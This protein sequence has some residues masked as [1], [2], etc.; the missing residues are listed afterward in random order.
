MARSSIPNPSD[1][2]PKPEPVN[3]S[4]ERGEEKTPQRDPRQA[5]LFTAFE[6]SGDNLAAPVI[7][8]LLD[9]HPTLTVYAWGGPK[10][11]EAGATL[12]EQTVGDAAMGLGALKK[13]GQV[14]REVR[15]IKRWVKQYRVLAHVPVDSPAANFPICKIIRPTGARIIHLVA[16][17]VWAWAPWRIRK[18]RRLT[19]LVLCVLPFEEQYFNDRKVTA[20]FIGHPRINRGVDK[21][22]IMEAMHGLPSGAPRIALLP[23][24]RPHEVK[25]NLKLLLNAYTELQGRHHGAVGVIAAA[26]EEIG[27]IVRDRIKVFPT[28]LHMTV[29]DIDVP[30]MWSDICL[31]VS[32]TVTLDITR[33]RKSMIGVYKTGF[34]SVLLAKLIL[35]TRYRLLPNIIADREIVPEFVPYSGGCLPIVKEAT[36]IIQ[37]SKISAIQREEMTRI[38][39]RYQNKKP[40][41]ESAR[42]I[43]RMITTGSPDAR[44]VA[45]PESAYV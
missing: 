33:H 45:T 38:L 31:A 30:V 3:P 9:K 8:E 18:L 26:N 34:I 37:D 42:Y 16:P 15:R 17:Q 35:R 19:D 1:S 14:R 40:A 20:R 11:K 25:A 27:Q 4:A 23:G 32:G 21:D 28:G 43:L 5:V 39:Q 22:T 44:D 36:R 13:A 10:M 2:T 41:E 29:V 24:S 6:P 12:V 7:R